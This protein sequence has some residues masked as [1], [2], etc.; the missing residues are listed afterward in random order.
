MGCA[1]CPVYVIINTSQ[2]PGGVHMVH[3]HF[4]DN[5]NTT[6]LSKLPIFLKL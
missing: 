2:Q 1:Q 6:E 4:A 3:S 5:G